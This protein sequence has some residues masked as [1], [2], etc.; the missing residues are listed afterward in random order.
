MP[1]DISEMGHEG[2]AEAASA[3]G[4]RG[5]SAPRVLFLINSLAGGGAERIMC[6]LLRYSEALR[7]EFEITLALLDDEERTY[8][9]PA[10]LDVRQLNCGKSS[11]RSLFAVSRLVDQLRPD[12]TISFLTR[13]NIANVLRAGEA[14]IIS[15]R[16]NTTAHFPSTLGGSL[17]KAVVR[18]VYP[19]AARVIAVSQGVAEELRDNYGVR[20][21]RIVTIPNP[22]DVE[23]I[24]G[25]AAQESPFGI[26][27]RYVFAAGRL[28]KSKNFP[29]L[30]R[31]FAAS[32]IKGKLVIAGEGPERESILQNARDCGIAKRVVLLGFVDNP[33]TLM[34]RA[35]AFVLSSNVEG[36]PNS[37][38]EA[39]AAGAPVI[40]TNSASG[41]SE[42]LAE[43]ARGEVKGLTF[44]KHGILTPV[45][46]EAAMAEALRALDDPGRRDGYAEKAKSRVRDFAVAEAVARYWQV[47]RD[48][49]AE[50]R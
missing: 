40:S 36:F 18:A 2:A 30:V 3:D 35:H 16:A 48:V 27:E 24:E 49:L 46:D 22:V 9:P 47:V 13:A 43:A 8:T 12:V 39:M 14:S 50:R 29:L 5:R 32:G 15:E 17:S 11:L 7:D 37:L 42:I 23:F 20:E 45:N 19:R 6:T 25:R 33:H 34:R 31:A 26:S 1:A 10:W 44:A 41:P 4:A 38:V 21:R 28:V